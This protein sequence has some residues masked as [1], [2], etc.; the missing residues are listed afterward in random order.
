MHSTTIKNVYTENKLE[1]SWVTLFEDFQRFVSVSVE[2]KWPVY[3]Y[4]DF[5]VLF[6]T[7][8]LIAFADEITCKRRGVRILT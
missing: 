7:Y 4:I 3:E 6:H 5:V 2:T 1:M 8:S